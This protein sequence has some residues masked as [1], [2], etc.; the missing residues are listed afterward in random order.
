MPFHRI[1]YTNGCLY[2]LKFD[3]VYGKMVFLL[4]NFLI[5]EDYDLSP[6]T[7]RPLSVPF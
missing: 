4:S 2:K 7:N 1:G 5:A 6:S 3:Y